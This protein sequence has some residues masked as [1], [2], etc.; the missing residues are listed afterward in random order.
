MTVGVLAGVTL[1]FVP[2]API[3]WASAFVVL[4]IGG[5]WMYSQTLRRNVSVERGRGEIRMF[6]HED[7]EVRLT[8][9]NDGVLPVP[10]LLVSDSSGE[11]YT[12][13]DSAFVLS[14]PARSSRALRYRLRAHYRGLYPLGPVRMRTADP[15]GLFP[16]VREL[17]TPGRVIV[18]PRHRHVELPRKLGVPV[19]GVRVE[20]P[21]AADTTRYRSLRDY[22]PG[23][24][25][26][27]IG[28]K[29]TARHGSLKTREFTPTI[30]AP[31]AIFLN[32]R[33]ADFAD[34]YMMLAVERC[35]ETA[36]SLVMAAVRTRRAFRLLAHAD[37]DDLEH[38]EIRGTGEVTA[39]AALELLARAEP[40]YD[41]PDA[42]RTQPAG[43]RLAATATR[44]RS[45]RIFYVGPVLP[46]EDI[47]G[48]IA[49]GVTPASIEL[50]YVEELTRRHGV[51]PRDGR[52]GRADR[53]NQDSRGG[54]HQTGARHGLSV[55]M[56]RLYGED[57]GDTEA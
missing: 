14:V 38:E 52:D 22:V 57:D 49:S 26:R 10:M 46:A 34:R 33:A 35:V 56:V 19:G 11:L 51:A 5:S 45:E 17:D 2:Y 12:R 55:H 8:V 13:D 42:E 48:L 23:D 43:E 9:R 50:Y 28:W 27:H 44:S 40:R 4:V 53:E 25:T 36:A 54:W 20:T 1:L 29:A 24:D 41:Y 18:Y 21:L 30:E 31:I 6:R 7:A 47:D 39:L 37:L 32:L 3:Q 15:L 16:V